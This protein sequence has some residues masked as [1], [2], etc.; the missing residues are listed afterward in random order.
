MSEQQRHEV[1]VRE[2]GNGRFG[3][4]VTVGRHVFGADEHEAMGGLDTGPDPFEL[5]MAGLGACTTMTIRMY[6]ARKNWPLDDV[7]VVVRQMK[8]VTAEGKPLRDRFIRR[9][10]LSGALD[11][12]QRAR[13]IEIADHC[14]VSKL[15]TAGAEVTAV[16]AEG[17][18]A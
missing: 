14:P 1:T 5:V 17:T 9:I 10:T 4:V 8:V 15:L 13:L 18:G 7:S 6:A 3:Q 11:A 16:D 12:G 2:S